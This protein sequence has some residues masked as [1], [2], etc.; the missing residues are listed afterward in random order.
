MQIELAGVAQ[1]SLFGK[2][3]TESHKGQMAGKKKS[4]KL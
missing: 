1:R 4:C 2:G 3:D